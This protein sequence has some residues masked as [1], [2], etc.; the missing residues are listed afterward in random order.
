MVAGNKRRIN[1]YSLIVLLFYGL[2]TCSE[3]LG[4]DISEELLIHHKNRKGFINFSLLRLIYDN[5]LC[6]Y[7]FIAFKFSVPSCILTLHSQLNH[8]EFI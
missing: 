7:I 2:T 3:L 8:K 1:K 6:N 4:W 5:I